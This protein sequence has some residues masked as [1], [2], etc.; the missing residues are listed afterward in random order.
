MVS[1]S[2]SPF[3]SLPDVF[4]Q[5]V[6]LASGSLG[7]LVVGE[8]LQVV[9]Q[10]SFGFKRL[11]AAAGMRAL[12]GVVQLVYPQQRAGEEEVSA[13]D[14]VV[15][16]LSGVFGS[17]VAQQRARRDEALA[18]VLAAERTLTCVDP[19]M[20]PPGVVIGEGL[21]AV[22]A[23]VELLLGVAQSVHLQVV[24]DGEALPAVAAGERL[25]THVEQC[26]V[27]SQVG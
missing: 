19:L 18:A 25:L 1:P 6:F 8:P 5:K 11:A 20:G 15:A 9:P 10:H 17:L 16:L 14:A 24:S 12:A 4:S 22:R 3:N 21:L 26:D 27:G 7:R 23:L 13:G 2:I